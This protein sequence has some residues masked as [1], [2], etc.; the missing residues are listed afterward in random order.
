MSIL[1]ILS[2]YVSGFITGMIASIIIA[3]Y[4][5]Q[6]SLNKKGQPT[7][8]KSKE[9]VTSRMKKVRELTEEQLGIQSNASG[10][11][12]NAMEGRYKNGL[13]AMIKELEEEKN[14]LL[15]SIISDGFDPEITVMDPSGA[16]TSKKLSEFL[17]ESGIVMEPKDST[18]DKP[19]N[20]FTVH[21]GG[22]DDGSGTTH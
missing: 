9:S 8:S 7:D 11:Q 10:P 2:I 18:P 12:K 5:G 3:I 15:K 13:N 1:A 22:K 20:K 14:E 4:L 19:V 16:V 17:A 21:K 6:R